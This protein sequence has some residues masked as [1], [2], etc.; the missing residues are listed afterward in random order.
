MN[1]NETTNTSGQPKPISGW[2]IGVLK[3]A[4]VYNIVAGLSMMIFYHEGF[5]AL[6]IAKTDFNLPIQLVGCLVAIFG[7]GYWIVAKNPI[8]NRN[9]LLLG[10]LSKLLGPLLAIVYIAKGVLPVEML[11]VLF[12]ADTV[13]LLPFWMTYRRACELA[14]W[15]QR[16][17][18]VESGM[19]V[20]SSSLKA[21]FDSTTKSFE[22]PLRKTG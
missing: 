8:E 22:Q 18:N 11:A 20:D 19:P 6:G 7:I 2:L 16:D 12:F 17:S 5:K 1:A 9:V 4:A 21:G 15:N 14:Q 13:Y 10:F 3:I